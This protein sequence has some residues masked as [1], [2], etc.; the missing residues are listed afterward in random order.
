MKKVKD[1]R[2]ITNQQ[3]GVTISCSLYRMIVQIY[4]DKATEL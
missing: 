2:Q 3:L 1:D 4:K